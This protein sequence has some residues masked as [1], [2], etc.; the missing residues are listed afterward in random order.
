[1]YQFPELFMIA[2]FQ[3]NKHKQLRDNCVVN[4]MEN[5]PP[6]V[7]CISHSDEWPYSHT[8]LPELLPGQQNPPNRSFCQ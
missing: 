6:S 2:N 7:D 4:G 3:K 1:M 5:T 8:K